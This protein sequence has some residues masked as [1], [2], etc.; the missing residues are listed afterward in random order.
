MAS[1]QKGSEA[2]KKAAEY[3]REVSRSGRIPQ[4]EYCSESSVSKTSEETETY[5]WLR[6]LRAL[7]S[8]EL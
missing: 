2:E 4:R 6:N 8:Q 5:K 7:S 1:A 3:S